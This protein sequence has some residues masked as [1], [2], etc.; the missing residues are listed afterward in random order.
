MYINNL[1]TDRAAPVNY[2]ND[3][4]KI[5]TAAAAGVKNKS[6]YAAVMKDAV[7]NQKTVVTFTTAGD[8]IIKEAFE[9]MKMDPEWEEA[10][11]NKVKEY[12][13]GDY[14]YA[15]DSLQKSYNSL[16]G[17]NIMTNYML[18]GLA[19]RQSTLGLGI[20]GY[21]PYGYGGLAASAYGNVMNSAISNS[22]LGSF[23]L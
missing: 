23:S 2:G 1:G 16:A 18:Q 5:N 7:N 20:S 14:S 11:M 8:I 13:A 22:L 6:G 4:T 19:G 9:K 17:Q 3:S 15:A 12:Y 10:V 21:S